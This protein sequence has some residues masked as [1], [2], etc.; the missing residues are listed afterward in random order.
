M[1]MF[2][3]L[4]LLLFLVSFCIFVSLLF[5]FYCLSRCRCLCLL[6]LFYVSWVSALL[7][8]DFAFAL[9]LYTLWPASFCCLTFALRL[10]W[11]QR[12]RCCCQRL[13]LSSIKRTSTT[14]A[15]F[16]LYLCVWLCV[17]NFCSTRRKS[18]NLP[19]ALTLSIPLPP[20]LSDPSPLV[21][22]QH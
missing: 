10:A 14:R 21:P 13:R 3:L 16:Q 4:P 9:R 11:M 20:S 7:C 15:C 8:F 5:L 1:L 2:L 18:G 12:S 22:K 6:P 19:T 17:A